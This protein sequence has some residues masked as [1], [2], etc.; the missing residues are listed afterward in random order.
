MLTIVIHTNIFTIPAEK[1]NWLISVCRALSQT[2]YV[3]YKK[4]AE[5]LLSLALSPNPKPRNT[6]NYV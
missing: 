2:T 6:K 4:I 1:E 5:V 3:T